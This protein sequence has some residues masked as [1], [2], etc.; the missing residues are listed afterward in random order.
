MG[1]FRYRGVLYAGDDYG[2]YMKGGG[3]G[4]EFPKKILAVATES[5][6]LPTLLR[7]YLGQ[8]ILIPILK[9]AVGS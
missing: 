6:F 9:P 1:K 4:R 2:D 3:N 8:S 7:R 5:I